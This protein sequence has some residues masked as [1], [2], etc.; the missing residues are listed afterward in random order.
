MPDTFELKRFPE[1]QSLFGDDSGLAP[2]RSSLA[3][4]AHD[5]ILLKII[6]GELPGGTELK[7]TRLAAQ[8]EMSRT[9]IVKALARLSASGIVRQSL[10]LRAVVRPGAENWLVDIHRVRQLLEPEAARTSCG[11][12]PKAVLQDLRLLGREAKPASEPAWHAAARW[13]D[14]AL[15]LAVAEYCGNLSIREILRHCWIYK[16]LSYEAGGDSEE[17]LRQGFADHAAILEALRANHAAE[18]ARLMAQH[19]ETFAPKT[20][21][22]RIV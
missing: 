4:L 1:L 10:N 6:S 20:P 19:L 17:A 3:D 15:H 7:S 11:R 2:G 14:L 16:R 9:P 18:A 13:F 22:Q 8:L 12:I 21:G 5:R